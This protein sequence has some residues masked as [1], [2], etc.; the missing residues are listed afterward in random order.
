MMGLG[1]QE[2]L[3]IVV[4]VAVLFG[5]KRLPQIGR[6][7]GAGIRE[8]KKAGKEILPGDEDEEKSARMS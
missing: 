5:V 7:L 1:L 3:I 6:D 8:F 4:I 2:I